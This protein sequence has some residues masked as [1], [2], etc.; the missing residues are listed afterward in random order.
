[1][2]R[3]VQPDP[4]YALR[5]N[6]HLEELVGSL[7]SAQSAL[8]L[9]LVRAGG[10]GIRSRLI[11]ICSRFGKPNRTRLVSL[12]ALV[13]LLHLASLLHDDVVDDAAI[14]RGAPSAHSVAGPEYAVVTGA[15]CLARAAQEAA[16]LGSGVSRAVAVVTADLAYGELLDI[17]RSFDTTQSVEDYLRL[18]RRKT[19]SLFRFCCAIGAIE[20]GAGRETVAALAEFGAQLG[21][22]FQIFDDCLDLA[23]DPGGKP[24]G[25]DHLL[26]LF[27]LPTLCALGND[28]PELAELLLS[29]SLS[30]ADLPRIRT[31]VIEG[32]GISLAQATA[33]A[34]F[35]NGVG[36]LGRLASTAPGQELAALRETLLRETPWN[37]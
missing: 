6:R 29:P 23:D 26:G 37:A 19:G 3:P 30:G 21:T 20:S 17:E 12:G 11:E 2:T 24:R 5:V 25:T 10:K 31:L 14:R 8:V 22:A 13:E 9:P 36:A 28:V 4:T 1:M 32:Q 34:H 33:H 35:E 7:P 18:V 27:G 15:S 16:Q